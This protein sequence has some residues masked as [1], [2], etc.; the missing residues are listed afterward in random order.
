MRLLPPLCLLLLSTALAADQPGTGTDTPQSLTER[1]N[2]LLDRDFAALAPQRPGKPDLYVLGFAGD[3]EENV[4]R[5]EV[6]YLKSLFERRF[7]AQGRVIMLINHPDSLGRAPQALASYD[8]LHDALARLGRLM[9]RDQDLL[10]LYLTMHGTEDHE[11]AVQLQPVLEDWLTP[12]DVRTALDDAGI[13][14]RVVVISACYSGGFVPALR[15]PDTL[16]VT[17]ARADRAS[18]GCGAESEATYFG[19]AWLIDGLNRTTNFITAYDIASKLIA[20]RERRE[21][22]EPSLPQIDI[23]ARIG[24]RLQAWES[25][26]APGKPVPY[27]Y[28]ATGRKRDAA[29]SL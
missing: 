11:L 19:R 20:Q 12:E 9:D 24:K 27:P 6:V 7:G 16:L 14:N 10:L 22:F 4:F 29:S 18:F 28:A 5:N 17:A 13:G 3:G 8:N 25:G 21:D 1:D 26:L 23:G 2:L 15:N